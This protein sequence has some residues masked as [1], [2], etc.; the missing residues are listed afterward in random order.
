MHTGE[1]TFVAEDTGVSRVVG[2]GEDQLIEPEARH[3]VEPGPG[4]SFAVEFHR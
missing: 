3:H 2:A 4:S 1:V